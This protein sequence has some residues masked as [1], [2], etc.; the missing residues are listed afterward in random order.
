VRPRVSSV[1]N[2]R[3]TVALLLQKPRQPGHAVGPE[4]AQ[5]FGHDP[6][7][8]VDAVED[9]ADVVENAGRDFRRPA[10]CEAVRAVCA[11]V[12]PHVLPLA[13]RRSRVSSR[14][15][16]CRLIPGAINDPAFQFGVEPAIADPR[17]RRARRSSPWSP[18]PAGRAVVVGDVQSALR[19]PRALCRLAAP[20]GGLF[21]DFL[22][23]PAEF[24]RGSALSSVMRVGDQML[25][26]GFFRAVP[27][28]RR[29]TRP[30]TPGL[31]AGDERRNDPG[32]AWSGPGRNG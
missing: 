28:T 12:P 18:R 30:T 9:V 22:H 26:A 27:G 21:G 5:P 20:C 3:E 23:P 29:T 1:R 11:R 7:R 8:H 16:V 17:L 6:G 10:S 15:L 25:E 2:R 24:A 19:P 13:A 14:L 32:A 31:I 4:E